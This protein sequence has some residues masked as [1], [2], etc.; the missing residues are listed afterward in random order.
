MNRQ[1]LLKQM[2]GMALVLLTGVILTTCGPS[3]AELDAQATEV[4]A[5]IFATQTAEAPTL[6]PTPTLTSTPTPTLP[7]TATPTP[8]PPTDTPTPTP[9]PTPTPTPEVRGSLIDAETDEPLAGAR[10]I[11]CL[12]DSE[13]SCC[14]DSDLSTM[15]DENGEFAIQVPGPGDYV[16][17]YN[18]SG[19]MRPGWDGLCLDYAKPI[20]SLGLQDD[21]RPMWESLG[22]GE[23]SICMQ[24][25]AGEKG[26]STYVYSEEQDL[27]F[28]WMWDKPVAATVTNGVGKINLAV[29]N[30][31]TEG[32]GDEF[33]PIR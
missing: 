20:L 9:S 21:L 5:I 8:I 30:V 17:F 19:D 16:V 6:T 18:V 14:I 25:W 11:L 28:V 13:S 32:C 15:T 23:M 33:R 29:W 26:W 24:V 27:G 12:Q 22:K 2:M 4:A 3:Q 1:E 31:A 10:I 7:P